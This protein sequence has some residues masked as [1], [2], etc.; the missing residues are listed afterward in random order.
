MASPSLVWSYAVV[1]GSKLEE[2]EMDA[3]MASLPSAGLNAPAKNSVVDDREVL[4]VDVEVVPET[5]VVWWSS[6]Q[7][8]SVSVDQEL[9]VVVVDSVEVVGV[10]FQVKANK[11]DEDTRWVM[12]QEYD[13]GIVES[14]VDDDQPW[15]M[16]EA[17]PATEFKSSEDL[18]MYATERSESC[19][20]G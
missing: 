4:V 9:E 10:R 18:T 12:A 6:L 13:I 5:V 15:Q 16:L 20:S 17:Q 3:A 7:S 2:V 14:C 8:E 1:S 11:K 19:W